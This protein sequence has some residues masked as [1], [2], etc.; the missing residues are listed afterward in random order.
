V[1][2]SQDLSSQPRSLR[3]DEA[4]GRAALLE[5]SSYDVSLDLASSVETF[6]S[7][8]RI[9]LSSS[10]GETFLDLEPVD[11][12][13]VELDGR[14]LD[15]DLLAG[16]RFPLRLSPGEHELYVDATMR[17]RNDGEGLHRSV[18]PADGRHYVYG[19]SFMDAAP[20]I[21]ACFD[22]PDLK[23]PFT[24]HVT[25]P[26][27][28][29]VV[30]NAPGEQVE[31]GRWEFDE[32]RPLSTYHVTLVAGPW[33]VV[34]DE[35]DGI[36]LSV[37]CRASIAEHLDRDV[38]EIL[39]L[40]RQSFDELHRLFGIRYPFGD[41]HQ[42]FVPEFN[43]GAMENPGCVTF[44]DPYV[45]TSRAT[46]GQHVVR[47]I[48][49]AHEMAHQWFGNLTTPVWWDDLWL[50][51]SFAEYMG[52]RVVADATQ[53]ADAWTHNAFARRQWGLVADQR[54]TTHPVAGN[55][56]T[57]AAAALQDFDGISYA[58]GSSVLKQL[59]AV[60]GDDVFLRG[61]VDHF[62][63]HRFGNATMHDLVASWERAGAGDLGGFVDAWLR[64]AGADAL[65][66]DRDAGVVRRTPPRG[67]TT[68]RPHVLRVASAVPGQPWR[69]EPLAVDRDEVR[70]AAQA[71]AAVLLDPFE[72]TW[73]L[74]QPD[75][76]TVKLLPA[77]LPTTGDPMLR[78]GI[79]NNVRTG[80]HNATVAPADVVGLLSAGIPVED[81]DALT[82]LLPWAVG[83]VASLSPDP[84][85]ALRAV[86]EAC[87]S[88]LATA[89]P[90]GHVQLAAFRGAVTSSLDAGLLRRWLGGDG[91]PEALELDTD[92]RWLVLVQ[93]AALGDAGQAELTTELEAEPTSR[94]RVEFARAMASRPTAEAKAWAWQR[95]TGEAD[96]SNYEL[97]AVGL[98]FWRTAQEPLTRPYVD[99]YLAE[100]ADAP[101][102][103]SGWV[104]GDV[105]RSFF[106]LTALKTAVLA[107]AESVAATDGL[108]A[109]VRRGLLDQ[110][111]ELRRRIAVREK[112]A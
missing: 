2:S 53:Y 70:F 87:A 5:V 104:L 57:D 34:R 18:D 52:N 79:W 26:R 38:E 15:R 67:S 112:Y 8:T 68:A 50:N 25:A 97:E 109:T 77:L 46:R 84:R 58:K 4:R 27:D 3:L 21:F 41:Y 73:A 89:P 111:D 11:L 16:R 30:A 103:H 48:T 31:P 105:V 49:I 10:G 75:P 72:D 47:A 19:M 20:S 36:P 76:V 56:A 64:S 88:R 32:S 14:P 85:S 69:I 44:R 98:G 51:E 62:E 7:R 92:L 91:L 39:T 107:R 37:S 110:A 96:A 6:R 80:L 86:H 81:D 100:V 99:R 78:A 12:H 94:T 74:V 60:V 54:P 1:S 66:L 40:T 90:G 93:L 83:K 63:R 33:H 108:D 42:A 102:R 106:P 43:A 9:R 101:A 35:H 45:F 24:L 82:A 61:V 23:A 13:R 65:S 28:W 71:D 17:F 95:F 22:Q 29:T 59:N 55:G